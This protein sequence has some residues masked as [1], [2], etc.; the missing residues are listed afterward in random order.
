MNERDNASGVSTSD[1]TDAALRLPASVAL[2]AAVDDALAQGDVLMARRVIAAG[3]ADVG[4]ADGGAWA[5][6]SDVGAWPDAWLVAAVRCEPPDVPALDA[7]VERYWRLLYARC[8]MLT[9]DRE[10]ARDLAQETWVRVLR[11]RRS[12]Q[13]DGNVAGYLVT[14]ATNVW[15]DWHRSA[16]RAG[17]LGEHQ[18]ASIDVTLP[19]DEGDGASLGEL[20]PDLR[21]RARTDQALLRLDIDRALARLSPR[22][23]DLLTARYLDGE[24]AVEIGRRYGRTEQTISAWVRQAIAEVRQFLAE[25][26]DRPSTGSGHD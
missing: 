7:L 5:G 2:R 20:L 14:V 24:S 15:R 13:P 26:A 21:A 19:E 18:L 1:P 16:R 6:L 17:P 10:R 8:E 12:L 4:M 25:S 9:V 22:S 23:R 3:A 11:A